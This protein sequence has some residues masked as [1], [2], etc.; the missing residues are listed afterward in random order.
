[1]KKE[2]ALIG[3]GYWGG[4]ILRNLFELGALHTV[5]DTDS[6]VVA[7]LKERYP[8][9]NFASSIDEV[10]KNKE[11]KAVAIATPAVT[12]FAL[13][14]RALNRDKDVFVEKPLALTTKEGKELV[15]IAEKRERILMVGHILIFHLAV[16]R[17]KELIDRGELGKIYYIYSNR[18]NIGKL[19]IEENILWSFAPHDISVILMLLEE[20]PVK[21]N[22]FG[23]DYLN[24]GIVDVTLTTL[25]FRNGVKAHI[26]VSW[27]HPYK[28]QKLVVVGSKAMAV[29]DDLSEVKLSL[30]PHRIEWKG[31]KIPVVEKAERIPIEIDMKEPLREELEHF[32]Y[33]VS[34]RITPRTDG[35]EGIRV[36]KILE[37]AQKKLQM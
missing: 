2:V 31:G 6:H 30:Y 7:D 26:Y 19:R 17:L 15:E 29:F 33:C 27:I 16:R 12:H 9:I 11:I 34:H 10:L 35:N 22:S 20:E 32:M 24:R 14:K 28:E 37:K 13:T 23:G 5:C 8:D 18:L 1:M 4:N 25:E 36:L 3:A 21:V